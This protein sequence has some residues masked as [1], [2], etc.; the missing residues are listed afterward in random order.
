M[1]RQPADLFI[2]QHVGPV[3][4]AVRQQL[5]DAIVARRAWGHLAAVGSVWDGVGT[6]GLFVAHGYL[7]P[8]TGKLQPGALEQ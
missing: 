8:H 4:P 6:A 7:D 1:L 3:S 2:V 5:Q